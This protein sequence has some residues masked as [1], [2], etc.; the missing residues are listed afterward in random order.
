[1]NCC[2][3]LRMEVNLFVLALRQNVATPI[4][5]QGYVWIWTCHFLIFTSSTDVC[6]MNSLQMITHRV[7][8][9]TSSMKHSTESPMQDIACRWFPILVF[10]STAK[11][12]NMNLFVQKV[13]HRDECICTNI[14]LFNKTL[15]HELVHSITHRDECVLHLYSHLNKTLQHEIHCWMKMVSF[16][17]NHFFNETLQHQPLWRWTY[18]VLLV[19]SLVHLCSTNSWTT[20]VCNE[21]ME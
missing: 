8:T 6:N 13:M 10:I 18:P 7:L 4:P 16:T 11:Y 17:C 3:Q 20:T 1:M 21:C 19:N 15:Q 14:H 12:W 9:V 5:A 2:T